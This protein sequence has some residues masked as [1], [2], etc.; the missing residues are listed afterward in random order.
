MKHLA[1]AMRRRMT[2]AERVLWEHLRA[3]RMAGHKFKRQLVIEPYIVDFACIEAKIIIEA[4]G[5]QHAFRTEAD[6]RRT[7]HLT[8][9]GY[10]VIC[11]WSHEILT[12]TQSVLERIYQELVSHPLPTPLSLRERGFVIGAMKN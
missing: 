12:K 5:G 1:R 6:Q 8:A 4:D 11:F 7:E 10:R 9:M 3:H 2:D